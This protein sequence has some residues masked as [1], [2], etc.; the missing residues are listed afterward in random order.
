[1]PSPYGRERRRRCSGD[2]AGWTYAADDK[3]TV[4]WYCPPGGCEADRCKNFMHLKAYFKK[5][6]SRTSKN[7]HDQFNFRAEGVPEYWKRV[8]V[9]GD[10][11]ESEQAE[12]GGGSDGSSSDSTSGGDHA[13]GAIAQ[14]GGS[15][16]R[17]GR[18]RGATSPALRETPPEQSRAA[19]GEM[20]GG[21]QEAQRSPASSGNSSPE[22]RA[23]TVP[24]SAEPR[25]D[26][27]GKEE[28]G[29]ALDEKEAS[30]DDDGDR[31]SDDDIG[32]AFASTQIDS[33]AAVA[34]PGNGASFT[35]TSETETTVAMTGRGGP[36]GEGGRDRGGATVEAR[37]DGRT[38]APTG[39]VHNA[40]AHD[41][42]HGA[43]SDPETG[44]LPEGRAS[45]EGEEQDEQAQGS[46]DDA[47]GESDNFDTFGEGLTQLD[48]PGAMPASMVGP[49]RPVGRA[50]G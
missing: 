39:F 44:G 10:G 16:G 37:R 46:G 8:E 17:S 1:M 7:I 25:A 36:A 2:R 49:G 12:K 33:S 14:R 28:E 40:T 34:P 38:A 45:V 50:G 15:P 47:G 20:A 22:S 41:A 27:G 13:A 19:E 29:S 24:G 30:D 11:Q 18:S 42:R 3:G 35:A 5:H 23:I 21:A 32:L 43:A 9:N 26:A 4:V 31:E 6:G 48:T